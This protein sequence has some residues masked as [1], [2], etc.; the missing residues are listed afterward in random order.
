M[1]K[2]KNARFYFGISGAS[3]TWVTAV[4]PMYGKARVFIDN[5]DYGVVDLYAP[6]RE[7]QAAK[8]FSNLGAGSHSVV[9]QV[10]REKNPAS[11]GYDVVLDA[12]QY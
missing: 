7:W 1:S 6:T 8:T 11:T 10:L 12:I 4:G 5:T 3:F 9:I 2:A